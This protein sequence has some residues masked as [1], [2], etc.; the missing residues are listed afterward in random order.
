MVREA[1]GKWGVWP[2]EGGGVRQIPG[3]GS[4]YNVIGWS[5]DGGSVYAVS[6]R[7]REKNGTVY[8]V[9]VYRVN[10]TTGK[11]D[12]WKTFGEGLA[13]G[14]MSVAGSYLAGDGGAYAY[15]YVQKLSQV[16]VIRGMK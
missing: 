14:T 6:R 10:V 3:L 2:L 15:L 12:P 4:N 7:Q 1:D 13:G 9:T 16:Y 5:P 11:I 8:R